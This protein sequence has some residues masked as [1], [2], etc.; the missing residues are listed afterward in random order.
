VDVIAQS[1]CTLLKLESDR[2]LDL[3]YQKP[4]MIIEICKRFSA[5]LKQSLEETEI[6]V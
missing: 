4:D 2:F 3:V 6:T 5:F 1:N